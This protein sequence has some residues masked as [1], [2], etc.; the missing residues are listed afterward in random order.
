MSRDPVSVVM[1][2]YNAEAFIA[3]AIES[4]CGQTYPNWHLIVVDDCS[5]DE[6]VRVAHERAER[7]PRIKIVRSPVN[8]GT[9]AAR[10]LG[11]SHAVGRYVAFLDADD[12]WAAEKLDKQIAFMAQRK[13]GFSFTAYQKFNSAGLG[14]V[15]T[16]SPSVS[17]RD[18]LKGNRIGCSTVMLDAQAFAQIR[19]P[20]G[21]GRRD[22]HP[23]W[24]SLL[25]A[26]RRMDLVE[27]G[28]RED[29]ALWLSLLR[30]GGL[31]HGLDQP[32]VRYRVHEASK[33][34][35]KLRAVA[36]Q[37]VVYRDVEKIPRMRAAW[38]L[39]HYA[40]R[41]VMKALR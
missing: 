24:R 29:Y 20:T 11:L 28:G 26:E 1:P 8:G 19:F 35:R 31:A 9:S 40:V 16:A 12:I 17:W 14:G 41:G 33:S 21:P 34:A 27:Q 15:I 7:D 38:Y 13:A 30:N 25:D 36:A 4:V 5:T 3:D 39:G 37:W 18:M 6:T 10:N 2:A 32:L 22:H 23:V